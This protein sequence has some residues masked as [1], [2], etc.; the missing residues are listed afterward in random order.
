[1]EKTW[2]MVAPMEKVWFYE[3]LCFEVA[4]AMVKVEKYGINDTMSIKF[5]FMHYMQWTR[6]MLP[7]VSEEFEMVY[8][9]YLYIFLF[10]TTANL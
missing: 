8:M 10:T 6:V 9:F 1:M 3:R 2:F 7:V 5:S 4:I